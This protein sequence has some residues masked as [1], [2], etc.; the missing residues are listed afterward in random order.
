MVIIHLDL[1]R[2][3]GWFGDPKFTGEDLFIS[4][5]YFVKILTQA[6]GSAGSGDLKSK[7]AD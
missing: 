6:A 2:F 1:L 4:S 3:L 7:I 5:S